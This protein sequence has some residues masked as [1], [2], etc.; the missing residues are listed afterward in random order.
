[1]TT[2]TVPSIEQYAEWLEE[3]YEEL[4]A[5]DG[6]ATDLYQEIVQLFAEAEEDGYSEEELYAAHDKL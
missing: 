2:I 4:N 6:P 5:I 3:L 1:M